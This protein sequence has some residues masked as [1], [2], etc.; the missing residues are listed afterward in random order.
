MNS[1]VPNLAQVS[2]R[3]G[4]SVRAGGF[5]QRPMALLNNW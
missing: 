3:T 1:D 2:L 4:R 5:V